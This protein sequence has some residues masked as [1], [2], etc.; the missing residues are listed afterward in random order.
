LPPEKAAAYTQDTH[1][2]AMR[3]V[4]VL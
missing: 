4:C 3:E 1:T 2:R